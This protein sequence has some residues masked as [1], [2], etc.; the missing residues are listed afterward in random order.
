MMQFYIA[1]KLSI[2][3]NKEDIR[4][5]APEDLDAGLDTDK[6]LSDSN[7]V[8]DSAHEGLRIEPTT[9]LKRQFK[10]IFSLRFLLDVVIFL[11]KI[12]L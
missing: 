9:S 2:S 12:K 3:M 5:I 8:L 1:W 6:F 4:D 7:Y 10:S 11:V